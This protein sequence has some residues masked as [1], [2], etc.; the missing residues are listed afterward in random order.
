MRDMQA[1]RNEHRKS[2]DAM[3]RYILVTN[4]LIEQRWSY[5]VSREFLED[6]ITAKQWLFMVILGNMFE[7]PP[8]MQEMADAMSTTHQNIKQLAVRLE[9]KGL[10]RIKQDLK[11][12]RILR[13]EPTKRFH[14]F[15][16]G[17]D[18]RDAATVKYLF[19]SL[20]NE[21][22]KRLFDIFSKLEEA[23]KKRYLE[24]RRRK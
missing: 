10:I 13:L 17:R 7:R 12:R 14:E 16:A 21:E 22:V 3:E 18:E 6:G 2:R 19:D 5:I 9:N 4:F 11:N 8:S 1:I 20:D 24:Y 23:S 15:W